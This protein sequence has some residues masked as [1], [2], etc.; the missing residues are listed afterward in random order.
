MRS[1]DGL[2]VIEASWDSP[3]DRPIWRPI[4]AFAD[5]EGR[6]SHGADVL[7]HQIHAGG[8]PDGL[9]AEAELASKFFV[10]RNTVREALAALKAEGLI[11]RGP[12][13]LDALVGRF[14]KRPVAPYFV[15]VPGLDDLPSSETE[16]IHVHQP[17]L[18]GGQ[19]PASE[20]SR[21]RGGAA[22][23]TLESPTVEDLS[24]FLSDPDAGVRR[25][26]VHVLTEHVPDEYGPALLATLGD[27]HACVDGVRELVEVLP[28]WS[29][30]TMRRA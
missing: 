27:T 30:S 20:A 3:S 14:L 15:P 10:S 29:P 2:S 5:E 17:P 12:R 19:A 6:D 28:D 24:E 23:L 4:H 13:D 22:L 7:R 18:V 25:T 16:P 26:A 11:G 1:C 21:V 9:P 8:Y